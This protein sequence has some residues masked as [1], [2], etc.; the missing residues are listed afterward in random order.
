M[1]QTKY[2]GRTL[3][4]SCGIMRERSWDRDVTI[5]H[6]NSGNIKYAYYCSIHDHRGPTLQA[7]TIEHIHCHTSKSL[8]RQRNI[9]FPNAGEVFQALSK[10][11]RPISKARDVIVTPATSKGPHLPGP[12]YP[13]AAVRAGTVG[14]LSEIIAFLF[15]SWLLVRMSKSVYSTFVTY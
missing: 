2:C 13:P 1:S 4:G 6:V 15:F 7:S 14:K 11:N 9:G 8:T 10:R 3:C 12:A 5:K